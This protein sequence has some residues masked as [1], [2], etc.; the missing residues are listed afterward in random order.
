MPPGKE[1][2]LTNPFF[3]LWLNAH[4]IGGQLLSLLIGILLHEWEGQDLLDA[5]VVG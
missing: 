4:F 3:S 5:V 2:V 1:E